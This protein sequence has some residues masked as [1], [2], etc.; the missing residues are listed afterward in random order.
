[1]KTSMGA[2]S[3]NLMASGHGVAMDSVSL[4]I[5]PSRGDCRLTNLG[6]RLRPVFR[7]VLAMAILAATLA[8]PARAQGSPVYLVTYVSVMPN[9]VVSGATLLERYRDASRKE[10]GNQRLDV[11]HETTRPNRFAILE[12]WKD[13]VGFMAHDKAASTLHFRDELEKIQIAP[14]D[15]RVSSGIYGRPVKGGGRPGAI[16]VLTHVDVF[17]QYE[18][19][20]LALLDTMSIDTSQ[21]D[22]NIG[23]EVLPEAD[24]PNHFTVVEE[25]TTRRSHD[26]HLMAAHTRAFRER[27]LPM[28]GALYDARV[29]NELD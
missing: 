6:T 19:D 16:Y 2:L 8:D 10:A 21:D 28:E 23:Y 17:P 26:A 12:V 7:L 3:S 24:H 1:M 22:G 29:Y 4:P 27:L 9:A 15:E 14:R 5:R 25:W 11:L 13:E 20:C 18:V